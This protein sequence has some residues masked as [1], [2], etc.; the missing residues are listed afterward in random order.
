MME[1]PV[2][3][4]LR[5]RVACPAR[6]GRFVAPA[7]Y[8]P[9][10]SARQGG[11]MRAAESSPVSQ[12]FLLDRGVA[13]LGRALG[14]GPRGSQVQILSPRDDKLRRPAG[15]RFDDARRM[16]FSRFDPA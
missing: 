9:P 7:T 6:Y 16:M 11:H 12:F 5:A 15:R 1:T 10:Q 2:F 4:A 13:Q 3:R 14:S 8:S